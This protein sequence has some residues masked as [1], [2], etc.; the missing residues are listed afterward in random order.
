M[1]SET[2]LQVIYNICSRLIRPNK[3]LFASNF[4]DDKYQNLSLLYKNALE[5][6]LRAEFLAPKSKG[7]WES[8][9]TII[10]FARAKVIIVDCSHWIV[11]KII[12]SHRTKIIYVG[13]GGGCYKKMG[14]ALSPTNNSSALK[15]KKLYGQFSRVLSTSEYF[16]EKICL[17]YGVTDKDL[18][19]IGLPRTDLLF[20]NPLLSRS[21]AR[22]I[23]LFA[24]SF[25][26]VNGVRQ[27]TINI[28]QLAQLTEKLGW[29]VWY[30]KHPDVPLLSQ[31]PNSWH[32]CDEDSY[33]TK[34]LTPS[35]LITD[36]SSIMFDFSITRKPII[37][38]DDQSDEKLWI[39][40]SELEGVNCCNSFSELHNF[41]SGKSPLKGSSALFEQQMNRCDGKSCDKFSIFL[42][43]LIL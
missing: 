7:F 8:I 35:L 28:D 16:D 14:F 38:F 29:E 33:V 15:R 13:H 1:K 10:A 6:N 22:K 41:L 11:S 39:K 30:S 43:E 40:K 32:C 36:R 21:P 4:K 37:V 24:P 5:H 9:G 25:K 31:Y 12:L 26:I 23:I 42:K 3:V 19:K 34:M 27:L 2:I 18:L 20:N 17:N